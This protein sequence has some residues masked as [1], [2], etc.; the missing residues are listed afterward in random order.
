[1]KQVFLGF[2]ENEKSITQEFQFDYKDLSDIT[3]LFAVYEYEDVDGTGFILF[4]KDGKLYEVDAYHCSC[5]GFEGQ[6]EPEETT[7]E[8]ILYR[9]NN[10]QLGRDNKNI[11]AVELKE[12]IEENFNG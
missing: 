2:F 1:M 3:I 9:I 10:G 8:D 4:E 12:Y 7:I 5:S 11:F 6:W